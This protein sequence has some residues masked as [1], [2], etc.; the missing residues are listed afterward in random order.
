[1]C[2]IFVTVVV[3]G[4]TIAFYLISDKM[5]KM[6]EVAAGGK[7]YV[8][9]AFEGH[10][11][12]GATALRFVGDGWQQ[13][14]ALPEGMQN[15]SCKTP[16]LAS[17]PR[18]P[19]SIRDVVISPHSIESLPDMSHCTQLET[20][21][22]YDGRVEHIREPL[23]P[24]L[25]VLIL[26]YNRLRSVTATLPNTL[27]ELNVSYNFLTEG[28]TTTARLIDDHNNHDDVLP[29]NLQVSHVG[30]IAK[31]GQNVHRSAIQQSASTSLKQILDYKKDSVLPQDRIED[32]V[33]S[34]LFED[35][36]AALM[37]N[38]W[39]K[40]W[41]R[42]RKDQAANLDKIN[43]IR[44]QL[45]KWCRCQDVHSRENVTY[46][47]VLDRVW[48]I[49]QEHDCVEQLQDILRQELL[50]S[51]GTCFTGRLTRL[52]STLVGFVPGVEITVSP[53]EQMQDEISA[54]L[55]KLQSGSA[56]DHHDYVVRAR[57]AVSDILAEYNIEH[58]KWN[59]WLDAIE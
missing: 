24:Q 9:D 22:M 2:F 30:A 54:V 35:A 50:D 57:Q 28:I 18:L 53:E 47:Q 43:S 25:R 56:I 44:Q 4:V 34:R 41:K 5:Q 17:M 15:L 31:D 16:R 48:L 58:V 13:L 23:P 52:V 45:P 55:H 36:D 46:E 26:N 51:I 10:P 14:P 38:R 32:V 7:S 20:L 29:R 37:S 8:I 12:T 11:L 19:S 1:M 59:A 21:N 33:L 6:V 3:L 42:Q 40:W 39:Y 27:V 49:I